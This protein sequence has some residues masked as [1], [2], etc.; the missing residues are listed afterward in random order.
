M[1]VVNDGEYTSNL[2]NLNI[3]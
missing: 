1:K 2:H 3:L